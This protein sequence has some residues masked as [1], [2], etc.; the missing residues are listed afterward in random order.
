MSANMKRREFIT[1]LGGAAAAWPLAAGAQQPSSTVRRIGFLSPGVAR[2]MAV[3]GLVEAF[4]QGLKEYGWVEGQNISVEYRFAEGKEEALAG[5][6][7]ALVQSRLDVIVADGT[8]AIQAAKNVTQTVPIVM[9]VSNDPVGTGL[10]ASLN[11]PGGNITGLS[12]LTG[13]LVSKWLQLLTE[14]VP[15]LARVAV[16][17][18]PLNPSSAPLLEQTKA[19]AQS[20]G[21]EIHVAEVQGPDRFESAFAAIKAAR[22]GALIVLPDGMLY[23]QHPR[24]VTFSAASHLPALF[25]QKEVVEAGG[26]IAYGPNIPASFRRSAAYVDKILQGAKP[27]D[28]PVEQPTIFELVVNLETARAIGLTVPASILLRADEV[29]E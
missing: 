4:R 19:A 23:S 6:A 26:L 20:L 3:R 24:I 28:L 29:I 8:A 14:I 16:L 18:N 11:R 22:A 15:G 13:E 17:S 2:T 12:I 27:A 7:A 21:V 1:L 10:V 25:G 5:I 9:A